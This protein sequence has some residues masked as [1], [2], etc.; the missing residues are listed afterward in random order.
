MQSRYVDEM[1]ESD[2]DA[3]PGWDQIGKRLTRWTYYS[4]A[5]FNASVTIGILAA[6]LSVKNLN[7][8]TWY[9]DYTS[10]IIAFISALLMTIVLPSLWHMEWRKNGRENILKPIIIISCI[11]LMIDLFAVYVAQHRDFWKPGLIKYYIIGFISERLPFGLLLSYFV[12][13]YETSKNY[14]NVIRQFSNSIQSQ[15]LKNQLSPHALFNSLN[16][17]TGIA[18][19]SQ[20]RTQEALKLLS[21]HLRDIMK[22]SDVKKHPVREE[23]R[24]IEQYIQFQNLCFEGGIQIEWNWEGI[25][26]FEILPLVILPLVENAIKHGITNL[27]GNGVITMNGKIQDDKIVFLVENSVAPNLQESESTRLGTGLANLRKRLSIVY[28]NNSAN[29]WLNIEATKAVS[30]VVVPVK[31]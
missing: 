25:D 7:S 13:S 14:S 4:F 10:D 1:A 21:M 17:I 18:S 30:C 19:I 28:K 20:K 3:S 2:R 9:R 22:T 31:P 5:V 6:I 27:G 11:M 29:L 8:I 26:D 24:I 12:A 15:L 16:V 23:R